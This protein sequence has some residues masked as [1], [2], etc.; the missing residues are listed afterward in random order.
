M[1]VGIIRMYSI[2][3]KSGFGDES[4]ELSILFD[5]QLH[6]RLRDA[7]SGLVDLAEVTLE[8]LCSRIR[9]E[10]L[11]SVQ[12][13]HCRQKATRSLSARMLKASSTGSKYLA[14]FVTT[15]HN[16]WEE[17]LNYFIER[18]T[19]GFVEGLNGVLRTMMRIAFGYR[20][21]VNSKLRAFAELGVSHAIRR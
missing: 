12:Q 21:F 18:I 2:G 15:L 5:L 16:W 19:N 7:T 1:Q 11:V 13:V 8:R 3:G 6:D 17:I 4:S 10:V 9:V 14:K 20:N